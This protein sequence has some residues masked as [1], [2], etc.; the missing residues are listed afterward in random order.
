MLNYYI[1]SQRLSLLDVKRLIGMSYG[2]EDVQNFKKNASFKVIGIGGKP[3]IEV[4]HNGRVSKINCCRSVF[5]INLFF[6]ITKS[7]FK[8]WVQ[9]QSSS[10]TNYA[11]E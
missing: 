1:F 11:D 3:I 5:D 6:K 4:K 9:Y 2:N 10:R 7:H 8:C